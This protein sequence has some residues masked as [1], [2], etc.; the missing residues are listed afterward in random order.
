M[1]IVFNIIYFIVS[2]CKLMF[3]NG[4]SDDRSHTSWTGAASSTRTDSS[5]NGSAPSLSLTGG[6]CL[7]PPM[8]TARLA[9]SWQG[10]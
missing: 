7:S 4:C 9:V 10:D 5:V 6:L 3:S 8:T 1:S 2:L